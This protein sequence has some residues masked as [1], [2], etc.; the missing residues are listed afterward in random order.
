MDEGDRELF[1]RSVRR[2][3]ETH[4]GSAL[5]HALTELGWHEAI[6]AEPQTAI[7]VL[8][9]LQGATATTSSAITAVLGSAL[10]RSSP[11]STGV[12]LPPLGQWE[13]PGDIVGDSVLIRGIVTSAVTD[14]ATV[15]VVVRVDGA[16]RLVEVRTADLTMRPVEGLDPRLGLVEV[17]ADGVPFS[18]ERDLGTGDWSQAI[19]LGRLAI[20]SELLGT[21]RAMLE[22]ARRHALDRNQFGQPIA[23][24]QAVRHR[25]ADTLVALEA[26]DAALG[27]AWEERSPESAATGKALAG[28]G[29]RIAA[30]HCQQVL[31]GIGFT[32]EHDFNRYL[33]RALVL[34]QMLG[35]GRT[36]T[37]EIGETVLAERRLP[38]VLPL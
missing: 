38:P 16:E 35:A 9:E 20:S 2:A 11:E 17:T 19:A 37:R 14:R 5:D 26:A 29:A 31:A 28:R 25:L 3:T 7:S 32:T 15:G 18:A 8:F 36:L 13:P 27:A 33:R 23:M 30:R 21:A 22:L 24:F 10:G 1:E 12:V 34:D 6:S 4:S